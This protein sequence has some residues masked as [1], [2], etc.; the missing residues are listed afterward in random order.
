MGIFWQNACDLWACFDWLCVVTDP[1]H[2]LSTGQLQ[3]LLAGAE[4]APER[5]EKALDSKLSATPSNGLN[6]HDVPRHPKF[7][8]CL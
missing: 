6:P 7:K 4:G 8:H 5:F 1:L 3:T 2:L